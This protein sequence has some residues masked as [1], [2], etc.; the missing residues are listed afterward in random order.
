MKFTVGK[1]VWGLSITLF[2]LFAYGQGT[3]DKAY[4][5]VFGEFITKEHHT[6]S[7]ERPEVAE[8]SVEEPAIAESV[9]ENMDEFDTELYLQMELLKYRI[10]ELE[11][12]YEKL[13]AELKASHTENNANKEGTMD[14]ILAIVTT[15]LPVIIPYFTR[16][17]H[18]KEITVFKKEVKK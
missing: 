1:L 14:S 4:N 16:K 7:A 5:V 11:E 15:L 9:P 13:E 17:S 3:L 10:Q 6:K 2:L 12:D 8:E 18:D